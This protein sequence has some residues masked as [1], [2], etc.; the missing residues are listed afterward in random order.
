M[1][2]YFFSPATPALKRPRTSAT[3]SDDLSNGD[4]NVINIKQEHPQDA[5]FATNN[6]NNTNSVPSYSS[7]NQFNQF[8]ADNTATD[9]TNNLRANTT[10]ATNATNSN[11][12]N[13]G[14]MANSD[15]FTMDTTAAGGMVPETTHKGKHR[16]FTLFLKTSVTNSH[17]AEIQEFFQQ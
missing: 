15:E 17:S 16:I 4:P 11:D 6:A 2:D 5:V 10:T 8:F 3:L 9:Q 7:T 13:Q 1:T 12:S 14:F